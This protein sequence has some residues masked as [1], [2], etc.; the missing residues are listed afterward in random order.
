MYRRFIASAMSL[1]SLS[2]E[3]HQTIT[4]AMNMIGARSNT[5]EGGEDPAVYQPNVELNLL[6]NPTSLA[7]AQ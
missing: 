3:A 4:A 7:P 2:P 6:G 5:G 1:G